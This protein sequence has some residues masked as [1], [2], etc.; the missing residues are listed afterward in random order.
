MTDCAT[1]KHGTGIKTN[2]CGDY[3]ARCIAPEFIKNPFASSI[4]KRHYSD[5]FLVFRAVAFAHG[6][7]HCAYW[8]NKE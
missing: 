1:C 2:A 6:Y 8:E 7:V 5:H 3:Q 4:I